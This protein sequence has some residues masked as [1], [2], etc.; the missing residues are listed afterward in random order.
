[1]PGLTRIH[2]SWIKNKPSIQRVIYSSLW[3]EE[4]NKTLVRFL[5]YF[6]WG[7]W[8][9]GSPLRESAYPDRE[10][11]AAPPTPRSTKAATPAPIS[12]M[13]FVNW[14]LLVIPSPGTVKKMVE[15]ILYKPVSVTWLPFFGR[16]TVRCDVS[17]TWLDLL[18]AMHYSLVIPRPSKYLY[19]VSKV[20]TIF[21]SILTLMGAF[22]FFLKDQAG[23]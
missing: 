11:R 2:C 21:K 16:L 7:H 10:L 19:E 1:M 22:F 15:S 4:A 23:K 18:R 20:R 5:F 17:S 12:G 14:F 13:I 6:I 3:T 9:R 8:L